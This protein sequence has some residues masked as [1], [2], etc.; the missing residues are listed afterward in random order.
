MRTVHRDRSSDEI[1]EIEQDLE[2]LTRLLQRVDTGQISV[3]AL[4]I[5]AQG[6]IRRLRNESSKPTDSRR[7]AR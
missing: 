6:I 3:D 2:G 1:H 4:P 7:K 5:E